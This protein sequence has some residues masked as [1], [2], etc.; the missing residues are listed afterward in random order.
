[1]TSWK[2]K[3]IKNNCTVRRQSPHYRKI[4]VMN[5]CSQRSI[6]V[7]YN[8]KFVFERLES[9]RWSIWLISFDHNFYCIFDKILKKSLDTLGFLSNMFRLLQTPALAIW[10][11]IGNYVNGSKFNFCTKR[12]KVALFI[13]LLVYFAL[14][15]A[16]L[17]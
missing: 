10:K 14:Y 7:I 1:M 2:V 4:D 5:I 13:Y 3:A 9:P 17:W 12:L 11:L 8:T 16:T 15:K 6:E